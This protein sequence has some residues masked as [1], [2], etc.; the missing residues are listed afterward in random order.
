MARGGVRVQILSEFDPKGFER[1]QKEAQGFSDQMKALAK[2]AAA[3]F[4]TRQIVNFA[5]ST[6]AAASDLGES[7][8]AVNVTFGEAADGILA[9]GENAA[10]AVGL[11][12]REFNAF[13]VQFSGFTQQIAGA[14]GD[15]AQVTDDL[16]T[17][18]ADFA[19]V[20]NMDVPEAAQVFQS[21]LAGETE[22]IR[23]FGIDMS[24]A[25]VEAHALATG[26]VASKSEMT[27]AIKVQ[28]RYSLLMASTNK[29]AGDFANTSDSLANQQRILAARMDDAKATIGAAMI[30]ALE[31][32]M[33]VVIPLVEAFSALPEGLQQTIAIAAL[34]GAAFKS[35]ST[36]LQGVGIAASTAN[37]MLGAIGLVLGAAATIYTLYTGN[38]QKA[39][40][41]T[42]D[43]IAALRLEGAEQKKAIEA[44]ALSNDTVGDSIKG[45]DALGLSTRDLEQYVTDGT[46]ALSDYV[47][48]VEEHAF[49]NAN[50]QQKQGM[51]NNAIGDAHGLTAEQVDQVMALAQETLR[52]R[53]Q[54]EREIDTLDATE[55]VMQEVTIQYG[56][57]ADAMQVSEDAL[58]AQKNATDALLEARQA[59]AQQLFD[60]AEAIVFA[61]ETA[62]YGIQQTNALVDSLGVL[63]GLT[64]EVKIELGLLTEFEEAIY[65]IDQVIQ[66]QQRLIL[67]TGGTQFA[68]TMATL[69]L[70]DLKN[71]LIALSDAPAPSTGGGG[72]GGFGLDADQVVDELNQFVDEVVRYGNT[73]LGSDFAD[74][75][76]DGTAESIA[77][78]FDSVMM[79]LAALS[80][81][82]TSD[83]FDRVIST[84][85]DKFRDLTVLAD[86]RDELREQL[87]GI[88]EVQQAARDLF[89]T[90][91]EVQTGDDALSLRE[92]LAQRVQQ[93]RDFVKNIGKLQRMGFPAEIINDVVNAGLV[94]GAAMAAELAT[95]KPT[96]V[97]TLSAQVVELRRLQTQAGDIVG[98]LLG[99]PAVEQALTTTETAMANLTNAIQTDLYD[100]FSTFLTGLGQEVDRLTNPTAGVG[101]GSVIPNRVVVPEGQSINVTVN[102][103][104]GTDGTQ[105]G[106]QIV[107]ILNE[108]AAGGGSRLSSSLVGG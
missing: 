3:A 57:Y 33:N 97:A 58:V 40:N 72:G 10:S 32:V 105:V 9:L 78:T 50:A 84:L 87:E 104:V 108:Y 86:L 102:A 93:A 73:L 77:D 48:I 18:I 41:T 81:Q 85:A 91:L 76:F 66:A 39:V 28:A 12:A 35:L 96:E 64:T 14:G 2:T 90:G 34:A 94:D 29:V 55:S 100:A 68:A 101:G 54:Q 80:E 6:V 13:A 88:R 11:S 7:I 67:A 51:F 16:T 22:P 24:A 71:E 36:S 107:E 62:G 74:R 4:A 53:Q 37:K 30:P 19:S 63:D 92:Q 56:H 31:G 70:I 83:V 1:A 95:F 17:R 8:N 42:N 89:A 21:A 38:K 98:G 43:F 23:R 60:T 15:I 75:L 59:E 5:K 69:A 52:L 61:A 79:E 46:G 65:V 27:E 26:L 45:L 44:L 20:M 47:A 82:T 25:A 49:Q 106:R 99:A 103:G